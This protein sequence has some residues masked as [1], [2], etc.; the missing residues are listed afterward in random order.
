MAKILSENAKV[1]L[2]R[3]QGGWGMLKLCGFCLFRDAKHGEE[4]MSGTRHLI[5]SCIGLPSQQ[6]KGIPATNAAMLQMCLI[7]EDES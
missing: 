5:H 3:V 6:S 1:R 7:T 4:G 2:S